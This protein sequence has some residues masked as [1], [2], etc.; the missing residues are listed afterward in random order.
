MSGDD[1]FH[2]D[3]DVLG[4]RG[5]IVSGEKPSGPNDPGEDRLTVFARFE[6]AW[7]WPAPGE[8]SRPS[9]RRTASLLRRKKVKQRA[10]QTR[11]FT[12]VRCKSLTFQALIARGQL[13]SPGR[14]PALAR[15][16]ILTGVPVGKNNRVA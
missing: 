14:F 12:G 3:F 4:D 7:G 10:C 15:F 13:E 16:A 1:A 9:L 5:R 8:W 6:V 11:N 2:G